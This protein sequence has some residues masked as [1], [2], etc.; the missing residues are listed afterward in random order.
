[1]FAVLRHY[2]ITELMVNAISKSSIM[3][4]GNISDP[5]K[6]TASVLKENVLAPFLSILPID[7]LMIK[8]NEDSDSG[9]VTHPR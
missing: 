8:A 7:Y 1:M 9:V 3:V 5:F 6:V 4:D 2:G